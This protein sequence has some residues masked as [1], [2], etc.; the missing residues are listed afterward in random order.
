MVER[1]CCEEC[2]ESFTGSRSGKSVFSLQSAMSRMQSRVC[3][4]SW[5]LIFAPD[6]AAARKCGCGGRLR[7]PWRS[8]HG[9]HAHR[10]RPAAETRLQLQ[11]HHDPRCARVPRWIELG[12][13]FDSTTRRPPRTPQREPF[14]L[15]GSEAQALL[16]IEFSIFIRRR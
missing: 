10:E 14:I 1:L 2:V 5:R 6:A 4:Y 9:V 11:T 16:V 8:S 3:R 7:A 13:G 12:K 15:Y